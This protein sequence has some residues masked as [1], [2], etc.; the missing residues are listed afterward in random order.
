MGPP[1]FSVLRENPCK[2]RTKSEKR[3]ADGKRFYR[4]VIAFNAYSKIASMPSPSF[5]FALH[6]FVGRKAQNP[7]L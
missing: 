4:V 3:W 2:N 1:F 7:K 6:L 5:L